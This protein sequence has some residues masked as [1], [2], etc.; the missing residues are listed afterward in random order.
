MAITVACDN[1]QNTYNVGEEFVGRTVKCRNCGHMFTIASLDPLPL[2]GDEALPTDDPFA[3]APFAPT[4]NENVPV[5]RAKWKGVAT[6]APGEEAP[7]PVEPS[8]DLAGASVFRG[9]S[10]GA[11]AAFVML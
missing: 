9:R 3:N 6:V 1:C 5:Q 4:H 10:K 11:M 7:V 2:S 8:G